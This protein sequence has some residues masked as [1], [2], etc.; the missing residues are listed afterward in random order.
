MR[1]GVR[2]STHLLERDGEIEV[3][4]GIRGIQ[5][6]RLSKMDFG[7]T[8]IAAI[9]R[10]PP[11][12][13]MRVLVFRIALEHAPDEPFD[14]RQAR[15]A[16]GFGKRRDVLLKD[17]LQK[18][19]GVIPGERERAARELI[20]HD[21]KRKNVGP[22]VDLAAADHR[23]RV[24][25]GLRL[26]LREE[27]LDAILAEADLPDLHQEKTMLGAAERVVELAKG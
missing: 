17:G 3:R 5:P 18:L 23:A 15:V 2:R 25:A 21:A 10:A 26:V 7:R 4:L 11:G 16:P 6:Q 1:P 24:G 27:S 14:L 12:V 22:A 9:Q 19:S 13:E 8:M 20:H